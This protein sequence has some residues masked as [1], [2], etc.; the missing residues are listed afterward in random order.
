MNKNA[1]SSQTHTH[2]AT[3]AA[4]S[5]MITWY[6]HSPHPIQYAPKVLKLFVF[7]LFF[8]LVL[9]ARVGKK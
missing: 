3:T 5:H 6:V 2:N 8:F 7:C 9:F 4:K 1:Q